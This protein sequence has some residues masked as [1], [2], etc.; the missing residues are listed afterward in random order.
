ML[1]GAT[2]ACH[3]VRNKAILLTMFWHG[4]RVSELCE[5]KCSDLNEKHARLF[6]MLRRCSAPTTQ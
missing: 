2:K 5:L 1:S 3:L 6:V 4:L